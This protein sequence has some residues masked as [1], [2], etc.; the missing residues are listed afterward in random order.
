VWGLRNNSLYEAQRLRDPRVRESPDWH[1][2]SISTD[3]AS[4]STS[5]L[6]RSKSFSET[7]GT[8]EAAFDGLLDLSPAGRRA[9]VDPGG[10]KLIPGS[11]AVAGQPVLRM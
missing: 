5:C 9:D 1:V 10:H 3:R 2:R 6:S 4:I 8:F 7:A 11:C